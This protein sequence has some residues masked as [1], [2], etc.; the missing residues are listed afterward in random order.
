MRAGALTT[1]HC[2]PGI[3]GSLSLSLR[4]AS[5][6]NATVADAVRFHDDRSL[7]T[8]THVTGGAVLL[9]YHVVLCRTRPCP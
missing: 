2:L 4:R 3:A 9:C 8:G 1:T 6:S 5:V 7:Y